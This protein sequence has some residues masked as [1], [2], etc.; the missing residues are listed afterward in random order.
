M[1]VDVYL[2]WDGMTKAEK[3]AQVTGWSVVSGH[4]G[5]LRESYDGEPYAIPVLV[6]E[7]F[8][9]EIDIEATLR[10]M[11]EFNR[12]MIAF[13]K[14][15]G[16]DVTQERVNQ[17]AIKL[18][19]SVRVYKTDVF[20]EDELTDEVV[21]EAER[22]GFV[23][24]VDETILSPPSR[25]AL[26]PAVLMELRLEECMKVCAFRQLKIYSGETTSS[27]M[28]ACKSFFDFVELAKRKEEET[29][30]PC[31]VIADW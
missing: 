6:P 8:G 17:E 1:G 14:S 2:S 18:G 4:V 11:T 15:L 27:V 12:K 22:A 19:A 5:Y 21:V 10:K 3:D 25:G 20:S 30:K 31:R 16:P 7:A 28:N 24:E 29:G 13:V 26:I 23:N 9:D